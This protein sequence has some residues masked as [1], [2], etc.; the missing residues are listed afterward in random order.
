MPEARADHHILANCQLIQWA[1][2]LVRSRHTHLGE[3]VRF[4]SR[5]IFFAEYNTSAFGWI[6]AVDGVEKR[7][8]ARAVRTDQSKDLTLWQIERHFGKCLQSAK[9]FGDRL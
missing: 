9:A 2:D 3:L 6:N 4:E 5:Y 8:L 7:R 1:D